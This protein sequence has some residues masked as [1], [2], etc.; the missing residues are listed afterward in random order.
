VP[1]YTISLQFSVIQDFNFTGELSGLRKSNLTFP[2]CTIYNGVNYVASSGCNI[3]SYTNTNVTY[4][5][6]DVSQLCP[7]R[8]VS[9]RRNLESVENFN[10]TN[11][12][13]RKL[14]NLL[15]IG[16]VEDIT[17]YGVL[18]DSA[19]AEFASTLS[20]NP[21][22]LDLSKAVVVLFFMGSLCGFIIIVLIIFLRID[23]AEKVLF[24]R[25]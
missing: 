7:S 9:G 17:T 25:F 13:S 18:L 12:N 23:S 5:C 10:D 14:Q 4:G 11:I 19:V 6:F 24:D 1:A 8:L 3:S 2:A 15:T 22:T 16:T 20:I 21:F